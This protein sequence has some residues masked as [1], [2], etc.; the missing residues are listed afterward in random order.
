MTQQKT[1]Y[2]HVFNA[3]ID[4]LDVSQAMFRRLASMAFTDGKI[5]KIVGKDPIHHSSF[6][7]SKG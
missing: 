5:G 3:S 2:L 6:D 1:K 7:E 4:E